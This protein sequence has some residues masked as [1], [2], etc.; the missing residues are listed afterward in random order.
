MQFGEKLVKKILKI[1]LELQPP[2]YY[3]MSNMQAVFFLSCLCPREMWFG[4]AAQQVIGT[5][6]PG[7]WFC[8]FSHHSAFPAHQVP[9]LGGSPLLLYLR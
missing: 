4:E 5:T 7:S 2:I 9:Q 3:Y 6:K 1:L 8:S